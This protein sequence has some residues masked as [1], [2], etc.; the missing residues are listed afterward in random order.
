MASLKLD[1]ERWKARCREIDAEVEFLMP[2]ATRMAMLYIGMKEFEVVREQWDALMV[3]LRLIE[4]QVE[5]MIDQTVKA[6]YTDLLQ[7]YL[8]GNEHYLAGLP[9][10]QT[11]DE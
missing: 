2:L 9:K 7:N 10:K 6:R 11:T 8:E 3:T 4:P 1:I 5:S